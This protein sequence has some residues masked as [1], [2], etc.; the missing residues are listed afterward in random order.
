MK[1]KVLF[2]MSAIFFIFLILNKFYAGKHRK[3][4]NII[5]LLV[6]TCAN[7]GISMNYTTHLMKLKQELYVPLIVV[8]LLIVILTNININNI[9]T[10]LN[11]FKFRLDDYFILFILICNLA[12]LGLGYIR[13]GVKFF[14]IIVV[15]ICAILISIAFKFLKG[16]DYR[17]ITD[18]FSYIAIVNGILGIAQY[19]TGKKL[20]IGEFTET[21]YYKQEGSYIKRIVGFVGTN[22]AAGNFGMILFA[23]VLFNLLR[24]KDKKHFIALIFTSIFSILT[25]TRIGYVAILIVIL[26]Y[27]V[28]FRDEVIKQVKKYKIIVGAIGFIAV[29]AGLFFGSRIYNVLFLQRGNT[30]DSRFNQYYVVYDKIIRHNPFW[31]GIGAGQYQYFDYYYIKKW[32]IDIHSQ[33]VNLVV[34][35]GW[36]I[37]FVFLCFNLSILFGALKTCESKLE[38]SLV[39][40]IFMANL[41]CCN[42]N[43][44]QDYFIN[45][46]L[47]FIVMYLFVYKAKIKH[48][49]Y[50]RKH[51]I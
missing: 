23:I 40:G 15:Y 17:K 25:L 35:N 19:I 39:I 12:S 36:V 13:N 31:Y 27:L 43:P 38:K 22:N 49:S 11:D 30:Q 8:V 42:F 9:K 18:F 24:T 20:L 50:K 21:I 51:K 41:V 4:K 16:Y 33:Y 34:E 1:I 32:D 46:I 7:L 10:N 48:D 3:E 26:T 47:Y 2:I 45:N 28:I 44:N 14:N 29:V 5:A 37:A 6:I